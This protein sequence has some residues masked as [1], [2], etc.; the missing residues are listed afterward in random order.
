MQDRS[1]SWTGIARVG[2][3]LRRPEALAFLPAISLLAYWLGGEMHLVL[4]A[5]GLPLIYAVAGT[6]EE[7]ETA[8]LRDRLDELALRPQV[9]AALDAVL[10]DGGAGRTTGC[11]VLQF[12]EM[13]KL[14]DR[15][16]RAAQTEV[17]ARSGERLCA[18]LREGD[19]VARLEGGGFAVALHPVRRL[20]LESMIQLA[21]RLQAAVAAPISLDGVRLYVTCSIGFCLAARSPAPRGRAMLD[22]AQVAADEAQRNGP[23]AVRAYA[24]EMARKRADRDA[25]RELLEVALDGG[26]IVP[27]FQ[28]Q[29]CSRTGSVSGFEALARWQHPDRGLIPPSEFLSAIEEA[30]LSERLG[31]V[32]LYQAL[33]A[34]RQWDREGFSVPSVGVNFSVA[35]LRNPRLVERLKWELDRFE[36]APSRLSIEI[37]ET[38]VAEGASD[39]VVH[40]IAG[41]GAL[42]CGID[43]D[44]FGTG[45]ASITTIRRFALRRLKIDRSFVTRADEDRDQQTMLAA[46]ISMA[47]RLGLETLAEGVETPGERAMLAQLGCGHL[48]G[49]GIARPMP[50]AEAVTWLQSQGTRRVSA[51]RRGSRGI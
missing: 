30:G 42:G 31:E 51:A 21:A 3:R 5:L 18:A 27:W 33:T 50:F 9:I 46:I 44:D 14:L 40:N 38:V 20:D 48:Q 12:D 45:H 26:Q 19:V 47:E 28:P 15:H 37:L 2:R 13:E 43:L 17:L 10:A 41:L 29:I 39:V 32:M 25:L 22:A 34:L 8:G 11:L 23:G 49:F 16:G 24:P 36:L 7:G 6:F 4:V 35:E 1:A